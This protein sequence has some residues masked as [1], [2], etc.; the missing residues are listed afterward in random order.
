MAVFAKPWRKFNPRLC[1]N[2]VL[3]AIKFN[4]IF[5]LGAEQRLFDTRVKS[6][7]NVIEVQ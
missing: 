1:K 4:S 2:R 5:V 7:S 3:S 6:F